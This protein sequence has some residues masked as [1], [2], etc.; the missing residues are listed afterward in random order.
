MIRA[1][2]LFVSHGAPTFALQPGLLGPKLTQLGEQ[3]PDLRAIAVVSAHWQSAGVRVMRTSTPETIHDFGG[4]PAEL[5]R[6][7]Y[8]AP[9]SPELAAEAA[10]LLGAAGFS[11]TFDDRRGLDHGA[12]VPLRY[13]KPLA[14][15][16]VFQ[17]SMPL[18]LDAPRALK[19][20]AALAPLRRKGVLVMGSGSLTHNLG[21]I[22]PPDS[23]GVQTRGEQYALAFTA[24]IRRHIQ[25]RDIEALLDYRRRAPH[26]ARAHP[27]EEHFLP[28]LVALGASDF[29]DEVLVIEGGVTYGVLSMESYVFRT[30]SA[31]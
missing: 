9:G 22:E 28:L 4:F 24:W 13:L 3:L 11:A 16:P 31:G 6:L 10:D 5:Y 26:A 12:W 17:V 19:L 27:S 2:A 20:G 30:G 21:E 15:T 23:R 8:G 29:Q 14:G 1:P 7:Q 18:D 25:E